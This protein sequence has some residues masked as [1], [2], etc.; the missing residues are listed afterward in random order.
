MD[1]LQA[2]V[3]ETKPKL[4]AL[5]EYFML[6]DLIKEEETECWKQYNEDRK[7]QFEK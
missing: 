6:D 1:E 7:G 5:K 3:N 4:R 2:I